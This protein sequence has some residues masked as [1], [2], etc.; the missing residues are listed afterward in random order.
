MKQPIKNK[1]VWLGINGSQFF[2]WK[3]AGDHLEKSRD[4][5]IYV[6]LFTT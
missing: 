1:F 4:W 5:K 3:E 6:F 2:D